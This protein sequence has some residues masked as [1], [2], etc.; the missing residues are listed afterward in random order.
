MPND[1]RHKF[2]KQVYDMSRNILHFQGSGG[3]GRL[4]SI[5]EKG[6]FLPQDEGG[7]TG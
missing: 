1:P 3:G 4:R 2:K 5:F 7:G 6:G